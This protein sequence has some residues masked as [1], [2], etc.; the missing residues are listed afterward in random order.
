MKQIVVAT[1][2]KERKSKRDSLVCSESQA[3]DR[4]GVGARRRGGTE[5]RRGW[6][7]PVGMSEF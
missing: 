2:E 6:V 5:Q 7:N 3:M 4:G 1:G